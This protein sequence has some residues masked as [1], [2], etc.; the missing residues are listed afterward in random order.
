MD[1]NKTEVTCATMSAVEDESY[2]SGGPNTTPVEN[3]SLDRSYTPPKP[4]NDAD[5]TPMDVSLESPS[6]SRYGR[7]HKPKAQG[8][9][10]TH[11]RKISAYLKVSPVNQIRT[12][13]VQKEKKKGRPRKV[14]SDSSSKLKE[15]TRSLNISF[16]TGSPTKSTL[17]VETSPAENMPPAQVGPVP[18]CEWMVGD[19][20]WARVGGHPYWPCVIAVDP[21]L[22]IFTKTSGK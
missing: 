5:N 2:S 3:K 13:N 21:E 20:A 22:N 8:D 7:S 6:K 10:V 18:G 14:H 19:L 11:D 15:L 16:G 1:F 4:V 17:N 9:F 12:W